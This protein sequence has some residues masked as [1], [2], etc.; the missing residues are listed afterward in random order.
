MPRFLTATLFNDITHTDFRQIQDIS[1]SFQPKINA[2]WNGIKSIPT[3]EICISKIRLN[4][5]FYQEYQ[6]ISTVG[7]RSGVWSWLRAF[8]CGLWRTR[9]R[10]VRS[11]WPVDPQGSR[12]IS[13]NATSTHIIV[14][15]TE[16]RLFQARGLSDRHNHSLIC[17]RNFS[18]QHGDDPHLTIE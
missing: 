4:T 11:L 7:E 2:S 12:L 14:M 1:G 13:G 6:G 17:D 3:S 5:N 18:K 16:W 10:D 15:P 8:A 9:Q